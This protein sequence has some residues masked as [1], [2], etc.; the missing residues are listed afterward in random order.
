MQRDGIAP[1][2]LIN[3]CRAYRAR[4]IVA[5]AGRVSEIPAERYPAQARVVE[6]CGIGRTSGRR[7]YELGLGY[8]RD[9]QDLSGRI[10]IVAIGSIVEYKIDYVRSRA[11]KTMGQRSR[12]IDQ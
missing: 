9:P 11:R 6:E 8:R 5:S 7:R 12:P 10:R 1:G 4:G 3:M 2:I